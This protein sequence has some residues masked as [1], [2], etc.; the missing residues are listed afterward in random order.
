V[1]PDAAVLRRADCCPGCLEDALQPDRQPGERPGEYGV[2][3]DGGEHLHLLT[4]AR[5]DERDLR[6]DWD[7]DLDWPGAHAFIVAAA[8]SDDLGLPVLVRSWSG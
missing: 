5:R 7:V 3:Y 1:D 8:T 4:A 6:P 2:R